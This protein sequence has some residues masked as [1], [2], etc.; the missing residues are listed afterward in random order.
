MSS[1]NDPKNR[2]LTIKKTFDAPVKLVWE[3]WTHPDHIVQWWAISKSSA[4]EIYY[5]HA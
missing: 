4:N 1:T 2:T 3:A 5:A